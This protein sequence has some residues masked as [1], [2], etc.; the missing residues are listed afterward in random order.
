M[1][2]ITIRQIHQ[3][4][5]D[6]L[7]L[8]IRKA[9]S[10]LSIAAIILAGFYPQTLLA[11]K[12]LFISSYHKGYEW[13]DGVE[14]GLRSVLNGKC[15][16][17]QFD[18]DT[19]RHKDKEYK[20]QKGLEAKQLIDEWSPDVV[21]AADDNAAKYVIQSH[22]KNHQIPF[23]FCGINWTAEEYGFPYSNVTGMIE[24]APIYPL[25]DKATELIPT[26]KRALYLGANTVTEGKNRARFSHALEKRNIELDS[27][28]AA[29]V[30]EWLSAYEKAQDEYDFIIIG[31][32]SGIDDWDHDRVATR[33]NTVS[34]KLSLTNHGWMMPYTMLGFTKIPEEQGEWAAQ[35]AVNIL[36]GT[37]PAE[38]AIVPNRKWDIW[39]NPSLLQVSG[40]NLPEGLVVKSK[41]AK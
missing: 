25:L 36:E 3:P 11:E 33:I 26:S 32:R 18:M 22:F 20:V 29:S 23:V 37:K 12:C 41:Q 5:D 40:I 39:T 4:V 2:F 16:I 24:V 14:R 35:A 38:I 1:I 30:S 27:K 13:S 21:I 9:E 28:L 7:G 8:C 15:K 19:K 31:S 17:K 10:W 34:Q 6:R